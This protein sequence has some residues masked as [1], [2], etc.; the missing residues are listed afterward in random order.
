VRSFTRFALD[1]A[2]RACAI[3]RTGA[4]ACWQLGPTDASMPLTPPTGSFTQIVGG[5]NAF[6]ALRTSGTTVCWGDQEIDV[7]AGW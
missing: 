5:L 3:D 6:Y 2:G 7:P 1:G 4:I